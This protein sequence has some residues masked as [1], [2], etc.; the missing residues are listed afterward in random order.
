MAVA[1][2]DRA[3]ILVAGVL[4]LRWSEAIGLRVGDVDFLRR[5]LTVRRTIAE[6]EGKFRIAET[7]AGL[8]EADYERP[9]LPDR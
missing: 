9:R 3:V 5:T 2:N 4:G 8:V 7:K 1:D 6:V